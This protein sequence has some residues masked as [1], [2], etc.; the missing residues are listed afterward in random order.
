MDDERLEDLRKVLRYFDRWEEEAKKD[1]KSFA[2]KLLSIQCLEDLQST[3][4]AF[5]GFCDMHLRANGTSIIPARM[6]SDIVENM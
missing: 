6:N 3:I 2:K 4:L 1:G 5:L